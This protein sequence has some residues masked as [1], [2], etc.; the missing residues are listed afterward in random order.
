MPARRNV[1]EALARRV[2]SLLKGTFGLARLRPGQQAVIDRVLTA[3]NTLAIMPTGAGKSLC[4]Q[5]PALLLAGRTVVVSPLIALMKDQVESLR[6]TGVA[7]VQLNSAVDSD[8]ERAALD[9]ARD[10]SA[11]IVMV[12]PERLAGQEFIELLGDHP[13]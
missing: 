3:Q 4:Y 10:G 12:T 7:A 5:L 11:R 1:P 13:T 2:R 6:E 8:E 9:A